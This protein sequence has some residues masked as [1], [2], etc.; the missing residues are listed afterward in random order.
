MALIDSRF[1]TNWR[2]YFLEKCQ[3]TSEFSVS[4]VNYDGKCTFASK[5]RAEDFTFF[6]KIN[7]VPVKNLALVN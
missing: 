1:L 6:F 4:K 2:M 7:N 3:L 5:N